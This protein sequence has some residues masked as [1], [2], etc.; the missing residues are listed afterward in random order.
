[1]AFSDCCFPLPEPTLQSAKIVVQVIRQKLECMRP[2]WI[3][4]YN[5]WMCIG[6]VH[7]K[8][9]G[10]AHEAY[11][12]CTGRVRKNHTRLTC[13]QQHDERDS[14]L[15]PNMFLIWEYPN[16]SMRIF[17]WIFILLWFLQ[18][19]VFVEIDLEKHGIVCMHPTR[20]KACEQSNPRFPII[21]PMDWVIID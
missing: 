5:T 16:P 14:L 19:Y 13:G 9:T 17:L 3:N 20:S 11:G 8:N 7:K 1:M 18:P 15:F 4:D 12:T 10:C 2:P 6:H 21:F